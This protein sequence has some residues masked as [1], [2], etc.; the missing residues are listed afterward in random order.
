[1][2]A[3][4]VR[5]SPRVAIQA[6]H[7]AASADPALRDANDARWH[8]AGLPVASRATAIHSTARA[9]PLGLD[10]GSAPS[11]PGPT[12][13]PALTQRHPDADLGREVGGLDLPQVIRASHENGAVSREPW[14]EVSRGRRGLHRSQRGDRHH[15]VTAAFTTPSPKPLPQ[16]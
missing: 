4:S 15:H 13:D 6:S 12:S 5:R 9:A 8:R 10:T 11:L 3:A 14:H 7:P 2:A 1:M 16:S